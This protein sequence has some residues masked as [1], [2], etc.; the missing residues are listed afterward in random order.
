MLKNLDCKKNS[1]AVTEGRGL[2]GPYIHV[3]LLFTYLVYCDWPK[4]EDYSN[5]Y[6]RGSASVGVHVK[7]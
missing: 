5:D 7:L 1:Q 2:G 4:R 3:N 6:V